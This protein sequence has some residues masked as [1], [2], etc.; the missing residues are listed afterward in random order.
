MTKRRT[1]IS[2]C[3]VAGSLPSTVFAAAGNDY[4]DDFNMQQYL[5]EL[6]ELISID[7]NPDIL[8]VQTGSR[9]FLRNASNRSAGL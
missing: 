2:G 6:D 1:F 8:K 3:L 9:I 5:K 7:S 4:A